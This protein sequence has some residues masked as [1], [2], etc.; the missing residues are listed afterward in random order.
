[1]V[2]AIILF[3]L[4]I[5]IVLGAGTYKNSVSAEKAEFQANIPSKNNTPIVLDLAQQSWPKR[6]VQPGK[7]QISNGHGPKG[8]RNT[9]NKKLFVQVSFKGFPGEVEL[10]MPEIEYDEKT[11]ALKNALQPNQLFK[12]DLTVEV[13]K[14][15]RNKLVGISGEIQFFNQKDQTL[16]SRIPVYIVN[17]NYGD[18]Y[19]QLNIE[20][21]T[22]SWSCH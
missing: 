4:T 20:R 1:M 2:T 3:V 6:L 21:S 11:L 16:L 15:D 19:Q 10:E 13:P 7:V 5:G 9:S 12:M 22:N 18:P 14:E 8:V 17:S